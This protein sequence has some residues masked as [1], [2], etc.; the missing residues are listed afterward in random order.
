MVVFAAANGRAG[1]RRVEARGD[2]GVALWGASSVE[3]HV[4]TH[5][6]VFYL[7]SKALALS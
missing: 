7:C 4:E 2:R 1:Q 3:T 6:E 5:V